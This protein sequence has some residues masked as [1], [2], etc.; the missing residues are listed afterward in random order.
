[1]TAYF[2]DALLERS[3]QPRTPGFVYHFFDA[4]GNL[5]YIGMT[6]RPCVRLAEHRRQAEW[7]AEVDV[8]RTEWERFSKYSRAQC[9]E[10][11]L[12]RENLPPHNRLVKSR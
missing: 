10:E 6:G 11:R 4:A 7:W 3:E 12:I 2:D 8:A 1:M 5:L 9:R